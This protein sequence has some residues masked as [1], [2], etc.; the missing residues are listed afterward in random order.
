MICHGQGDPDSFGCCEI[1]GYGICPM[2]WLIDTTGEVFISNDGET[3]TSL[4]A[5]DTAIRNGF[6]VNNP[7]IRDDIKDFIGRQDG[8]GPSMI[9]C[10]AFGNAA[11]DHWAEFMVEVSNVWEISDGPL[12]DQRWS[13]EFDVGG[14][15]EWVG[16][17]WAAQGRPRDWCV[18]FGTV[19][20][21]TGKACCF[22]E[23]QATNDAGVAN[24]SATSVSVRGRPRA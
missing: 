18:S 4:G 10:T 19:P 7:N 1:G 9:I 16:D 20:E 24:L 2:R 17:Q 6:G 14:S 13:E 23:D 8:A 3:L 5:L 12:A 21:G 15:A 11:R 22:T